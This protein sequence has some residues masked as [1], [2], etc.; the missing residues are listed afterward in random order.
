LYV[1]LGIFLGFS[2]NLAV[3]NTGDIAWRL[4]LGSAFIPAVPLL[5][6][7]LFCPESACFLPRLALGTTVYEDSRTNIF[8]V[9]SPRALDVQTARDLYIMY[10]L[11]L[12]EQQTLK[13]T[14]PALK[15]CSQLFTVPRLRRVNLGGRN[16]YVVPTIMRLRGSRGFREA[17]TVGFVGV[18]G[19]DLPVCHT[20][21]LHDRHLGRRSLLL[22]TF[23]HMAW[24]LLAAGL[25][26]LIPG[27]G[28]SRL[29]AIAS[30]YLPVR[31]GVRP[32]G[33]TIE[34]FP[35]SHRE[36]GMSWAV[37]IN[38][39]G[40]SILSLTFPWMEKA[41][42]PT[43]AFAFYFG[44]N[45]IAFVMIF[46]WVPETRALALEELDDVFSVSTL[47]FI[48]YQVKEVLW[49]R[50]AKL[51]PLYDFLELPVVSPDQ[52][53]GFTSSKLDDGAA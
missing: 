27:D 5:L 44:L 18:W 25:C 52:L 49:K 26:F 36:L 37:F 7:V 9:V 21:A 53:G 16:G 4:Q 15:R 31:G 28:S 2:A 33:R 22:A 30:V 20:R 6:S 35:L 17:S 11:Y 41:F 10:V 51:R 45:V 43:G 24:T 3:I 1:A 8:S 32:W 39:L 47:R 46:L 48:K 19:D 50:N 29:P 34:V 38:A 42:T 40:S 13:S 14:E 12:K 23:P